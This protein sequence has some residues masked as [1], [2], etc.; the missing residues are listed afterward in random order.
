VNR[1][2]EL[3]LAAEQTG[4]N[5]VALELR[6]RTCHHALVRQTAPA[7]AMGREANE[8]AASI[9]SQA[10]ARKLRELAATR[11][12]GCGGPTT[13]VVEELPGSFAGRGLPGT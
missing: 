5:T 10:L 9:A 7:S 1:A 8:I 6:C 12:P 11:C 2:P 13:K 4:E 3:Y